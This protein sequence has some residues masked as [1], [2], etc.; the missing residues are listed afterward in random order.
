M[1]PFT[2]P[3]PGHGWFCNQRA[4]YDEKAAADAWTRV[5]ALFADKLAG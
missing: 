5:K 4:D 2:D 1:N 3:G